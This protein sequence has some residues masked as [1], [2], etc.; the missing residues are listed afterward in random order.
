MVYVAL[1]AA[2]RLAAEGISAEVIDPRTLV[3]LDRETVLASARK[4]GRA[5]VVD[6][7][8]RSYG[9]GAELAALIGEEA[10]YDLD[11][12]VRRL[13]AMDVPI[14]FSPVLED[15]TVPTADG[16]AAEARTLVGKE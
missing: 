11:A 5:I 7:G 15:V 9:V 13:C 12:P 8:H 6:E 14:P 3:P 16:I 1:D 10:F 4:T 2:E